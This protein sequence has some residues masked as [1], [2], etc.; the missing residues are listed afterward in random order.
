MSARL[1]G[2]HVLIVTSGAGVEHDELVQP[3]DRLRERGARVTHAAPKG[4]AVHTYRHDLEPAETVRPDAALDAVHPDD[5]DVLVVPG[6]TVNADNLRTDDRARELVRALSAAGKPI[7]AICHGPWLLVDAEVVRGMTLTSY[8]SLRTDI[9][10]AGGTWVD[11]PVVRSVRD[12]FA[13]ITSR[14]PG[15][16]PDFIDAITAEKSG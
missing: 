3:R 1:D 15:D 9:V 6:G 14:N 13:L 5:V 10:N 2:T 4:E 16:L 11:E 8:P 12:G 7:A